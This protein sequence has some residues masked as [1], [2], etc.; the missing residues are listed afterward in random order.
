[1]TSF[2]KIC[3]AL[4]IA[5]NLHY[6]INDSVAHKWGWDGVSSVVDSLMNPQD[7]PFLTFQVWLSPT[8]EM[9]WQV[10]FFV[11]C[12]FVFFFFSH[13]VPD[14]FI[15]CPCSLY[16]GYYLVSCGIFSFYCLVTLFCLRGDNYKSNTYSFSLSNSSHLY[17]ILIFPNF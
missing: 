1:M 6:F 14:V 11:F 4:P 16:C 8:G 10:S 12:L 3:N 5:V 13:S 9:A 7:F 17:Y 15:F 2:S